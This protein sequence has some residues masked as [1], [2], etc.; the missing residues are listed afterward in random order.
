MKRLIRR[1]VAWVCYA[2][3][4]EVDMLSKQDV[5]DSVDWDS[6]MKA[7]RYAGGHEDVMRTM[8]GHKAQVIGEYVEDHY[9]GVEAFAYEFYDGT[10]AIITDSFGSCVGCDYWEDA[11][12]EEARNMVRELAI[13]ARLFPNRV[14]AREFCAHGT[15]AA[16]QWTMR[17]AKNL[18]DALS[19]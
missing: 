16:E 5:L 14:E 19:P 12:D 2:A 10:I 18:V 11:T 17:A 15:D 13:N 9:D 6:V 7:P 4:C 1:A 3:N 8:F